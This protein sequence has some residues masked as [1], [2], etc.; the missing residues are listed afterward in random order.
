VNSVVPARR[1]STI[2]YY[3]LSALLIACGIALS[4]FGGR[5]VPVLKGAD[6]SLQLTAQT[7][8]FWFAVGTALL[9]SGLVS[10]FYAVLRM[11]D[12]SDSM[13]TD[14][15]LRE[16]ST[17]LDQIDSAMRKA[18]M[19]VADAD[20]R[21]I[22]DTNISEEFR[23][24]VETTPSDVPLSIDVVGL[25]LFRFLEDQHDFLRQ[26]AHGRHVALRLL[27]QHP[28]GKLFNSICAFE[29][30]EKAAIQAEICR[31]L[32]HLE[33]GRIRDDSLVHIAGQFEIKAR[34]GKVFQPVTLFR[35]NDV[36]LARPRVRAHI[37]GTRFFERYTA[38][39]GAKYFDLY[40]DHFN[41]AWDE[42][43]F[44][45]PPSI[46]STVSRLFSASEASA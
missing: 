14:K 10:V 5:D 19:I 23:R 3:I 43:V 22:L 38:S 8:P 29:Q 41:F 34:F 40:K 28:E 44:A 27:V 26:K 24:I 39:D 31:V 37:R 9:A 30:K 42:S 46:K 13:R 18:R 12:D 2:I 1:R 6:G 7:S 16:L 36:I 21:C 32:K 4:I 35:V 25:T 17:Q 20:S 45:I 33:G 11:L 15:K